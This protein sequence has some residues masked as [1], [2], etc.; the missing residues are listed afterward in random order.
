M[1]APDSIHESLRDSV[2]GVSDIETANPA[3]AVRPSTPDFAPGALIADRFQIVRMLGKG[4]MGEV[5]EAIDSVSSEHVALKTLRTD[6][7]PNR[8]SLLRLMREAQISRKVTHPNVCRLND[9]YEH[10]RGG[11]QILCVSMELLRGESLSEYL[12]RKGPLSV[13]EALPIVQ[14]MAMGL[15]AAHSAGVVHRDFK[16]SNVMLVHRDGKLR[17]VVTDFGLARAELEDGETAFTEVG[18]M[19]F[20]PAYVAPEQLQQGEVTAAADIYSF[21]IVLYEMMTGRLPFH[22]ATRMETALARLKVAPNPPRALNPKLPLRWEAVILRCLSVKPVHR[23]RSASGATAALLSGSTTLIARSELNKHYR[24]VVGG[25]VTICLL[26]ATLWVLFGT[27]TKR[28]SIA[29]MEPIS[30]DGDA[31]ESGTVSRVTE[32]LTNDLEASNSIRV[33]PRYRVTQARLDLEGRTTSEITPALL[34]NVKSQIDSD[35]VV[36]GSYVTIPTQTGPQLRVDLKVYDA[37]NGDLVSALSASSP[38]AAAMELQNELSNKL[39]S[40]LGLKALQHADAE[41]LLATIPPDPEAQKL[42][43]DAVDKLR[44]RDAAAALPLLQ[45][46]STINPKFALAHLDLAEAYSSLGYDARAREEATQARTLLAGLPGEKKSY[47]EARSHELA[48]EWGPAIDGYKEL[49]RAYPDNPEYCLR[50]ASAQGSAHLNSEALQTIAKARKTWPDDPRFPLAEADVADKTGNYRNLYDAAKQAATAAAKIGASSLEAKARVLVCWSALKLGRPEEAKSECTSAAKLSERI[51]DAATHARALNNMANILLVEG[52][53]A[54][55]EDLYSQAIA[56][57]EKIGDEK[58]LGGAH[59]NYG[60]A[61][62]KRDDGEGAERQYR[63]SLASA[64]KRQALGSIALAKSNIA[65]VLLAAG[66]ITEADKFYEDA[67]GIARS[68]GDE[69]AIARCLNNIG[70]INAMRGDLDAAMSNYEEALNI[71][72]KL[73][74]QEG[75]AVVLGEMGETLTAQDELDRAASKYEE[76]LEIQKRLGQQG[77]VPKTRLLLARVELLKGKV[78]E[79]ASSFKENTQA[80]EAASDNSSAALGHSL[81]SLALARMG[82]RQES[83][84]E[85]GKA[86]ALIA[87]TDD[88]ETALAVQLNCAEARA[89]NGI[90]SDSLLSQVKKARDQA[91][92]SG[93]VEPQLRARLILAQAENSRN[94]STGKVLLTNL[95]DEARAKG[96]KLIARQA[97]ASVM[98]R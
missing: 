95:S 55:A 15:D 37:S 22:G 64:E 51:Q 94:R 72:T 83:E 36:T 67:L 47:A 1:D 76:T 19:M 88:V 43:S 9:I 98:L 24:F 33:I 87:K 28:R 59:L 96:F 90:L 53:S 44:H 34:R 61:L 13:E 66:K 32:L 4:G 81:S 41:Q 20:T 17:V 27:Q 16:S 58:N 31:L 75:R 46:V 3:S 5:Y 65:G 82:K 10:D 86:L 85:A 89:T 21:G 26:L 91:G 14:Q 74:F 69:N 71:R 38:V 29:V 57:L 35:Y 48:N 30:M 70:T 40:S 84:Q 93:F 80:A 45:K 12:H 50:L 78:E 8:R 25:A 49:A 62:L 97:Q 60:N 39:R 2:G 68:I 79:A 52:K 23:F 54:D 42:Y 18:E 63:L 6:V 73:G 77:D 56:I 7:A 92:K 11:M